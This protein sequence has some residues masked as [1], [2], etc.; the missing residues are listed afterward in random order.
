MSAIQRRDSIA[1]RP[2]HVEPLDAQL[3]SQAAVTERAARRLRQKV[4]ESTVEVCGKSVPRRGHC[5]Y[6]SFAIW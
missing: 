1:D 3:D 4:A 5:G 6:E 2:L